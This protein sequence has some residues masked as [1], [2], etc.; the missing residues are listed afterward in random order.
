MA[1]YEKHISERNKLT[2]EAI[3]R[4]EIYNRIRSNWDAIAKPLDSMGKFEDLIARL[5]SIQR[6]DRP[7]LK[8]PLALI[9]CA[10]NGVVEE[11]ISQS[12]Q[13]VTRICAENIAAHVTTVGILAKQSHTEVVAVDLGINTEDALPGVI[14]RKVRMGTRN[15]A[16]E[17]AMT[18]EEVQEAI[19]CGKELVRTY[20]EAGYDVIAIGEMGI[21]NTT[22]SAAIATALLKC[23]PEEV[24]GRGAGLS[25]QGLKRKIAVIA[26][27][28]E[29][30]DL[31]HKSAFQVLQYVGG[32]DIAGMVGVYLAARE[33]DMPIVLDGMISMVAALVAEAI[34]PGT[35]DMLIPSHMSKEPAVKKIEEALGLAPVIDASMALGEGTGAVMMLS[36][37]QMALQVYDECVPFA[38][39]GVEQYRRF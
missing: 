35:K 17:A 15:F 8:K 36:L 32:L 22:T 26:Q 38:A 24:T 3:E 18:E 20:K 11:G 12:D 10:D 39:S 5:G 13:S 28:V 1:C 7:T 37:L 34:E 16:K 33:W 4:T 29:D 14:Q 25:D 21:G 19:A 9:L 2:Q 23:K 31:Y 6:K 27:A 30:Y